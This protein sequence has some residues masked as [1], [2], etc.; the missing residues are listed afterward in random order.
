MFSI[1]CER[2][3]CACCVFNLTASRQAKALVAT[4][5]LCNNEA[6]AKEEREAEKQRIEAEAA[7]ARQVWTVTQAA[8][9]ICIV[10]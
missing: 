9:T 6:R 3:E 2:H 10:L 8:I 5:Q 1:P 4:Q 7:A